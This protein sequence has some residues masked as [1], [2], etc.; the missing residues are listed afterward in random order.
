MKQTVVVIE[1]DTSSQTDF[2]SLILTVRRIYG[3]S[4]TVVVG[5]PGLKNVVKD[6]SIGDA[7]LYETPSDGILDVRVLTIN[8]I[9][10]GL[11]VSQVSPR[12]G[13]AGGFV[14]EASDNS[15]FSSNELTHIASSVTNIKKELTQR[16]D[17]EAEKLELI[18]RKLDEI[19]AAS[20][21][22]GRKDWI[23]YVTGTLTS[24]CI[25]TAFSPELSKTLFVTVSS[26]FTWLFDNAL[27]LLT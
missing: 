6:M 17:I 24:L 25:S 20:G 7:V 3:D 13:I 4:C 1:E 22:L 26:A 14:D 27:K 2:S 11:L 15:P 5:C 23:N 19:Q 8:G 18:S 9:K 21:R 10:V 16:D 12:F